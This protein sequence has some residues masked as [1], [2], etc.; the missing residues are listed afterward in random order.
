LLDPEVMMTRGGCGIVTDDKV[1]SERQPGAL[2]DVIVDDPDA[3]S[4]ARINLR[5][6]CRASYLFRA[7]MR[8]TTSAASESRL[9]QVCFLM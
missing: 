4:R 3:G 9:P 2:P 5:D 8:C 1:V 7:A 6:R